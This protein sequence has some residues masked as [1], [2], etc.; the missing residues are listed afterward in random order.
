MPAK[1]ESESLRPEQ[2]DPNMQ[3][4]GTAT[5][6]LAWHSPKTA[7][8]R[9]AGFAWFDR[10]GIYRRLPLHPAHPRAG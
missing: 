8:F 5:Q 7:P 6:P 3:V 1:E 2:L 9:L 10:E 4:F